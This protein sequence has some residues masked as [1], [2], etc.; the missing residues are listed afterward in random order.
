[1]RKLL[2]LL[3]GVIVV[4]IV[5]AI[6]LPFLIPTETYKAE[7]SA[8]V[9]AAT[10]RQ[11]TIDGPLRFS[12]LPSLALEAQGVRFA[13]VEGAANPDMV[14]LRQLTVQLRLLPLLRGAV[15]V[16]RFVL[17]EPE[18]HLE[19][20]ADGRPNWQLGGLGTVAPS[21]GGV[22]SPGD[23]APGP[24]GGGG[25]ALPLTGVSLGD[26]HLQQG[27]VTFTDRRSG[28]VERLEAVDLSVALPDLEGPLTVDG[29]LVYKDEAVELD[30]SVQRPKD[31]LEGAA[32]P[33]G[34]QL[35]AAPLELAFEGQVEGL[36]DPRADGV[37]DLDVTSIRDLAVWLASPLEVEGDGLQR[38]HVSGQLKGSAAGVSFVG[39][40]IELDEIHAAGQLAIDL[41]G[42]VPGIAGRLELGA[43]D[44]NPYLPAETPA[45]QPEG[46]PAEDRSTD[47]QA[48]S[49]AR[50]GEGATSGS[51]RAGT[52]RKQA[53]AAGWSDEPIVLPLPGGVDVELALLMES[54]RV[55]DLQLGRTDLVVRL[56]DGR[57]VTELN[58]FALYGGAGSGRLEIDLAEG[59]PR[60]TEQ[61]QLEGLQALP[62]L[63][64]AIGF[65]R[66]EGT[67]SLGIELTSRGATQRALIQNLR[68][69]GR[70][71]FED[72]AIVGINLVAM[73]RNVGAVV[74]GTAPGETVKTD[75]AELSG[76]F[77]ITDGVLRNTDMQLLAPLLRLVGAGAIDLPERSIDYRIEPKAVATLEGQGGRRDLS[78]LVVPVIVEGPWDD[79]TY[80]PDVAQV[81]REL[82][83]N[84]DR[85]RDLADQVREID[86]DDLEGLANELLGGG[87]GEGVEKSDDNPARRLLKGLF[88]GG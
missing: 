76:S 72:G 24:S 58:E 30:L 6:A 84:P 74:R 63:S 21:V 66:L 28:V 50:D 48:G 47:N 19:I 71:R 32:S 38:L 26:V 64:A 45:E 54:L 79:L 18:I 80:R 5:A 87:D 13:N 36:D 20:D 7:L 40:A 12:V 41:T 85:V 69:D 82:I 42:E 33:L 88:G 67:T 83:E 1:M 55:R 49:T 56:Q 43:L 4:V 14:R 16:E 86:R 22:A 81:T 37:L 59:E 73:V 75:F 10:G 68:G 52:P 53:A 2:L 35:A 57:L 34:V 77:G 31:L 9:E 23:G 27:T 17:V 46:Q 61:F 29:S 11:L 44:L 15:E 65:D 39:A 25:A 62:F 70:V 51:D 60:I 8:R 3:A 78:G